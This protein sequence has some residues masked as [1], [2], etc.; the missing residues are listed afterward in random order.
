MGPG[1]LAEV[2]LVARASFTGPS[3][4]MEKGRAGKRTHSGASKIWVKIPVQFCFSL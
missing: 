1:R 2:S 3:P 4:L